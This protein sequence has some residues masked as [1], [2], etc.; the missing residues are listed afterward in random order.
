MDV[1]SAFLNRLLKEE[2]YIEQPKGFVDPT[3]SHYVFKLKKALYGL[4][5]AP[6]AWYEILAKFLL[7]NCYMR[8]GVEK[9]LFVKK[10]QGNLVVAQVYVDDIMFGGMSQ[11]LVDLLVKQMQTEFEM[12]VVGE[13]TYFSGF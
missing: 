7:N 5:Q 1:K 13:L 3:Y 4:M 11:D 2:V 6:N 9:T 8:R 12:S 10:S